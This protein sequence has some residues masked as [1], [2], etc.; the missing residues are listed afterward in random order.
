[1][2]W[3]MSEL[4]TRASSRRRN[5]GCTGAAVGGSAGAEGSGADADEPAGAD[6]LARVDEL[7]GADADELARAEGADAAGAGSP[8]V[9]EDDGEGATASGVESWTSRG[10]GCGGRAGDLILGTSN[11]KRSFRLRSSA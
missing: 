11:R 8:A 5:A 9:P 2:S 4:A 7:A 6:E 10:C 3:V 1:M